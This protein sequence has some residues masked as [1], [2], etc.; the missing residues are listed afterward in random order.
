MADDNVT[1]EPI[2]EESPTDK[3]PQTPEGTTTLEA[4]NPAAT[5]N[6]VASEGHEAPAAPSVAASA[7]VPAPRM[8][9][10]AAMAA[11][12][13]H[14]PSPA[15]LAAKG[16][17]HRPTPAGYS[18][19]DVRQAEGFGR[20]A[21][22]GTVYVREGDGERAVG[23]F[24]DAS[25]QEALSLYAR[26][27][28]DL[29]AKVDLFATRL[30]NPAIKPREIDDS[31]RA[32]REETEKPEAV[33]DIASLKAHIERLATRAAERKNE[34]GEARRE[35]M[36]KAIAERSEIVHKAEEIAS[37]LDDSTNWRQTADRFRSLFDQ[38]QQHQRT[39]VRIDK[40]DADALWK[41]FSAARTTFNQA[42][43]HWAQQRDAERA[44]AKSTKE[45]IIREADALKDS[46]EWGETSRRF[47][48]LMDRWKQAGRAGRTEDDALWARFREAADVFFGARQADR[49]QT[50]SSER[51][52]L[53]AKED[54]LVRAEALLP[55]ADEG[56]AKKARKALAAI[57]EQWD[58]IGYVPREDI[59]RIE[60]RL[61]AVDRQI[62]AVEEAA[63]TTRDP[64]S[65]ARRSSFEEQLTVQLAE[66]DKAI[67][68][69]TDPKRRASLEAEKATKQQWLDAVR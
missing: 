8:P 32:L 22:D 2:T 41:R 58:Q 50:N 56:A 35:A 48:E 62:K 37:S 29:K 16:A 10:P 33:G 55:V 18:D 61:D 69:E 13:P 11:K 54:L 31:L 59:R 57:Q 19:S 7:P 64:E 27:F 23:Q 52:N 45:Q 51:E 25:P 39:S 24:P 66:L 65:D 15:A 38:W 28:L 1:P 3:A 6:A 53:A 36:A 26:R 67:A 60:G 47:N 49:D 4:A 12:R 44:T 43:R 68:S 14:V 42:R 20:V 34:I 9:S 17:A 46:T 30:E 5:D 40:A 21:E 63:W